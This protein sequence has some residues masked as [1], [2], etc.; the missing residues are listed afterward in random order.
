M[1]CKTCD[2][3]LWGI[4]GRECPECGASF[5]PSEFEFVPNSV[6][7]CCPHCGQD[8]YGTG[9]QGHLSPAEFDCVRCNRHI[10]MDEMTLFLTTGVEEEQTLVERMPWLD[11]GRV[12]FFRAWMRTILM[13]MVSPGRLM[14]LTPGEGSL[15]RAW[16]FATLTSVVASLGAV[17][18]VVVFPVLMIGSR[19]GAALG[20][21]GLAVLGLLLWPTVVIGLWGAFTH[22]VLAMTGQ[23]AFGP[24]RTYQ[25]MCYS[26]A[27]NVISAPPCLG[28]YFTPVSMVWW[29][30]SAILMVRGGQR[31]SGGRAAAAVLSFP[32]LLTAGVTCL[33]VFVAIP[34]IRT[35][36]RAVV[37]AAPQVNVALVSS[38]LL[39][40]AQQHRGRAP[41]H[42]SE[43]VY[44]PGLPAYT[45]VDNDWTALAKTP[46]AN[47][48]LQQFSTASTAAQRATAQAAA[49][50]L[51][52]NVVAH[53]LGHFVFTCHGIDFNNADPGLWTV[54]SAPE[55]RRASSDPNVYI[56]LANGTTTSVP[57]A[58]FTQSLAAQNAL[59]A[60][61]GL[62]P[63]PDPRRVTHT[64]P[65][66]A[67]AG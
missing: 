53:R 37:T 67:P 58:T 46:V 11:R 54:V 23:R 3:R 59:R 7:F 43:L 28:V 1:R 39:I 10:C 26:A 50:A 42:A 6:R 55:K 4:L 34:G 22:A 65:A 36:Q 30:V 17:L 5:L 29:C 25:A 48:D 49:K 60:S 15:G 32:L 2:Y 33:I 44:D 19:S 8:Y 41:G 52:A 12:S 40:Y 66:T 56:G 9:P 31:V 64:Q 51:P 38:N 47:T 62:P 24:G 27:A 18:P 61:Q 14:R 21:W 57:R 35:A 63:L 45:L 20:M 13:G 16:W